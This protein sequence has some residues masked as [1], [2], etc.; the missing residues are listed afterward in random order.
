MRLS[1]GVYLQTDRSEPAIRRA[2][3]NSRLQGQAAQTE[4][5]A[6]RDRGFALTTIS[7]SSPRATRKRI[8]RSTEKPSSL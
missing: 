5:R 3:L 2:V 6:E 7:T 8:R 1:D 4:M